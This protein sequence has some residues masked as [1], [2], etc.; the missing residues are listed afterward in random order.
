[1]AGLARVT[2]DA[3][4][5]RLA[6]SRGATA[7]VTPAVEHEVDRGAAPA[8]QADDERRHLARSRALLAAVER[9]AGER[10][11][12]RVRERTMAARLRALAGEG[13]VVAV[14][15]LA[16]LDAVADRLGGE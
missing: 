14:V 11:L 4:E 1:V 7:R 9:P 5:A 2:R 12:D 8:R 16:H 6:A 13:A 3:V 15:G 10:L